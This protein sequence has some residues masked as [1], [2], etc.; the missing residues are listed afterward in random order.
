MPRIKVGNEGS[1]CEVDAIL[2]DKD[3]TLLDFIYTWGIWSERLLASCSSALGWTQERVD[4]M[5][6]LIGLRRSKVDG[7]IEDYDR[8]GPLAMGTVDDLLAIVALEG[9]RG[10]G[11]WAD[12][13]TIAWNAK[14]EADAAI[15]AEKAA[16]LL[17]HV[18]PFL[19]SC[20]EAGLKLAVVTADETAAAKRHLEW[21]GIASFFDACVGTDAVEN[22]KPFPDMA[23]FACGLLGVMPSRTAVIG[24]TNGDMLM[25]RAAGAATAIGI[26]PSGREISAQLPSAD[27]TV[28]SFAE[29]AVES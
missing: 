16:R 2:F 18:W 1:S 7:H 27:A 3:G 11:T 25:A 4:E 23:Q 10:G 29:L 13:K 17:P 6:K 19:E 8:N 12:A 5:E 21:L 20:R 15:E 9:Y 24:D 14:A 22:G 26:V 28:W